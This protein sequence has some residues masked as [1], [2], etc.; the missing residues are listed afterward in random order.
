MNDPFDTLALHWSKFENLKNYCHRG[1]AHL[2]ALHKTFEYYKI[3]CFCGDKFLGQNDEILRKINMWS[4]Y[5]DV[6]RG[7]CIRYN[8]SNKFIHSNSEEKLNSN[9]ILR[10]SYGNQYNLQSPRIYTNVAF[11]LKHNSWK[12]E[13][14][15]RLLNFN[16]LNEKEVDYLELDSESKIEEIVFGVYCTEEDKKILLNHV[17][18]IIIILNLVRC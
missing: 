13:E 2:G 16:P 10:M 18:L 15:V 8:F 7:Y 4:S 6:H 5:A 14:E 12:E 11:G 9:R 17:S 1:G 3:R